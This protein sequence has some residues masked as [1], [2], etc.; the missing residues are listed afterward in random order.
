MKKTVHICFFVFVILFWTACDNSNEYFVNNARQNF[1]ILDKEGNDL[2]NPENANSI[3]GSQ[4][5]IYYLVNGE[6]M[7]AY[8]Y[9]YMVSGAWKLDN[10]YGFRITE[11]FSPIDPDKYIFSVELNHIV[12]KNGEILYTYIEWREIKR[13][14]WSQKLPLRVILLIP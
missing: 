5:K 1:F 12:A 9:L 11:P 10:P 4:I 8:D 7:S 13:I 14:L 6:K 2:L 3:D